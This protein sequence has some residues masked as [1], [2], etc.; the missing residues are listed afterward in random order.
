MNSPG[1]FLFRTAAV[2]V[3][4]V[5]LKLDGRRVLLVGAGRVASAKLRPLLEAGARVQVVAPVVGADIAAAG[6][7][8][9]QR[10]FEPRDLDGVS[11]VVS[12]APRQVN[13]VVAREAA[14]RRIFVNAVDDVENASAYAGAIVRRA[15]VT[16]AISTGG[17]AP[18][19][20]ALIREA[21]ESLLPDN[22]DEWMA[23]ARD[24]RREWIRNR[25][26]IEDR[27]P[28]LLRALTERYGP[29]SADTPEGSR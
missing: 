5:F 22:L 13:G 18:A 3:F 20:A 16:I 8:I 17:E 26:P 28:L 2:V 21:L 25:V 12:A 9:S 29:A 24:A 14:R 1:L 4:P 6:V 7:E 11:Y 15:G 23:S 27:R 10:P 19:L